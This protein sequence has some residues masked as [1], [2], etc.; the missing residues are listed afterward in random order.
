MN[1]ILTTEKVYV[2]PEMKKRKLIY[3]LEFF[4]SVFLVCLL[5]SYYIYAEYDRN[6][7]EQVSQEMLAQL[8]YEV[9]TTVKTTE[10]D[11]IV[12]ILDKEQE[13][14]HHCGDKLT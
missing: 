4:V 7:A 11:V 14:K 1:Q 9:D 13:N 10:D 3:K 8:K 12:V 5:F 6:K 2:T